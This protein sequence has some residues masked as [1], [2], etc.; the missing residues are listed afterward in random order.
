MVAGFP[1][2]RQRRMG[3][4]TMGV[5]MRLN[6]FG[7]HI[8]PKGAS[9]KVYEEGEV[10]NTFRLTAAVEPDRVDFLVVE[11]N[12][13]SVPRDTSGTNGWNYDSTENSIEFFGSYRLS[14]GAKV[15]MTLPGKVDSFIT[16]QKR[17]QH[18]P[19]GQGRGHHWWHQGST[20]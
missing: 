6:F 18:Q 5:T 15:N 7:S 20:G 16:L 10:K 8:P 11:V 17:T 19:S 1:G 4:I 9:V 12:G 3:G 2:I 13:R 14:K